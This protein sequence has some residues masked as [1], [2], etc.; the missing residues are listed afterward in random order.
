LVAGIAFMGYMLACFLFMV[1]GRE[2]GAPV[3]REYV[4]GSLPLLFTVFPF[5]A[6][7]LV[8]QW[9][10]KVASPFAA[11]GIILY[12][13]LFFLYTI[14]H[15]SSIVRTSEPEGTAA[16]S[17]TAR[18]RPEWDLSPRELEVLD[19]MLQGKSNPQIA[20]SLFVSLATVKTHVNHILQK[21]NARN[22]LELF[23]KSPRS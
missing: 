11:V 22:R 8:L 12:F 10:A 18:S 15:F 21:A 23:A 7:E 17:P 16:A 14:G 1:F 13:L 3:F 4:R 20:A 9:T 5:L 6:A 2:K 19:L